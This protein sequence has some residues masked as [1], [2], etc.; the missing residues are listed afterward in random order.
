[1]KSVLQGISQVVVYFKDILISEATLQEHMNTPE[2]VLSRLQEASLKLQQKKC[3]F[4]V[5]EVVY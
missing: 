3:T 5:S 2:L 1:M 4:M